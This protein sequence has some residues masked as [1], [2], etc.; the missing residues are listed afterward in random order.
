MLEIL[1]ADLGRPSQNELL[2]ATS[3]GLTGGSFPCEETARLNQETQRGSLVF[4]RRGGGYG[5]AASG[6]TLIELLVVIAIMVLRR[7][8]VA[9]TG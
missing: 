6:F 2:R 9:E 3:A 5:L 8:A 4:V 7:H 1:R